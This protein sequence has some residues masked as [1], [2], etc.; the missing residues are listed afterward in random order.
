MADTLID[1]EKTNKYL[2]DTLRS[3]VGSINRMS[4]MDFKT[5]MP[6]FEGV[7]QLAVFNNRTAAEIAS[8]FT[9]LNYKYLRS[10]VAPR[11]KDVVVSK[12]IGR[13]Y[14]QTDTPEDE[15]NKKFNKDYFSDRL[16]KSFDEA[17]MTGRSVIVMYQDSEKGPINLV[18]YNLFRHRVKFDR[19]KKVVEAWLYVNNIE[20]VKQ[21]YE[22]VICE[23]RYYR[24]GK[25]YQRL[26]VY[27]ISYSREDKKDS[28]KLLLDITEIPEGILKM[29]EEI[30]VQFN[31]EKEL[32]FTNIGVFD[33]KY[34]LNNSKFIDSDIPEAMFVDAVDNSV[35]V[36]TSITD[37]EVEK[38]IGRGQILIPEFG[39]GGEINYGAQSMAGS[40]VLRTMPRQYKNPII[41]PY[42]T[43]SM[44]DSKPSN[45][46]FDIRSEQW[47]AQIDNDI[48]RLCASVGVS[49]LDY[50][51]RLLVSGQ[52]TDDE[53]NAMTDITINTV[54]RFR[55]INTRK[56][57][58]LLE[59]VV[60]AI[61]LS[62]PV[63]IRWSMSAILNPTKNTDLVAKQLEKGLISRKRAI[64]AINPDLTDSEVEQMLKEINGEMQQ[65]NVAT[66]FNNF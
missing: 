40:N 3:F 63:A 50:D 54:T 30:G 23:H 11:L 33:I 19:D 47:N 66:T 13:V 4:R 48:A 24:N 43:M 5:F 45:V 42:P 37:K 10:G 2:P 29:A 61:G 22:N 60:Q 58:E 55:N 56:V 59:T 65:M 9:E 17:A 12:T 27:G 35:I 20:G 18:S 7:E 16:Y 6:M 36:D 28:K 49:V 31:I 26:E 1:Y 52:R 15:L 44:E 53:I 62:K 21:G 32:P 41:M 25:P 57:N 34:T 39:K 64:K 8:G 46:Q 38:E 51:P 14:Y